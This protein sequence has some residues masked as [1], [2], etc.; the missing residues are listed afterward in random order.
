MKITSSEDELRVETG[1]DS[2]SFA[3]DSRHNLITTRK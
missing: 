2:L 1:D 3:Y